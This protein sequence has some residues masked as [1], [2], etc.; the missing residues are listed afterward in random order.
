MPKQPFN[1]NEPPQRYFYDKKELQYYEDYRGLSSTVNSKEYYTIDK[2][3]NNAIYNYIYYSSNTSSPQ[4]IINSFDINCTQIG[5]SIE[6]DKFYWTKDFESFL[7]TGE[8]KLVSLQSPSHSAIRIVKKKEELNAKLDESELE[9]CSFALKKKYSDINR[10][11]FTDKYA[12]MFFKYKEILEKYF[13]CT[14]ALE[15]VRYFKL[16][17]NLDLRI[18][19]L[20]INEEL[21][22]KDP[23]L[24][25]V[26][27]ENIW[28]GQKLLFYIRHIKGDNSVS[29]LWNKLHYIFEN[30]NYI[31][32]IPSDEDINQLIRICNHAPKSIENLK[33][34][35][36]SEQIKI[37]KTLFS[38]F[39]DDP[40]I[41]IS[42]LENKPI[43]PTLAF[44]ESDLLLLEL[45]VRKEIINDSTGKVCRVLGI[46]EPVVPNT[47]LESL[48]D[49]L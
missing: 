25:K 12:R 23:I 7:E 8:L 27:E 18:F 48:F 19:Q 40:I 33:G 42:I 3:D 44:D 36:L 26:E 13:T 31:D 1:Y 24:S 20:N 47:E 41:A 4:V 17:K 49:F 45:S 28:T 39:K 21:F 15:V 46:P 14:P 30:P 43:S 5:Y 22:P 32:T 38:K 16:H 6:E 9:L 37:V 29:Y 11:F 35:K 34:L 2:T 10:V